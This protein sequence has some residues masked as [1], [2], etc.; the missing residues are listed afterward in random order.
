MAWPSYLL[1]PL[2][3]HHVAKGPP[4]HQFVV[5]APVCPKYVGQPVLIKEVHANKG[6]VR[7]QFRQ[8]YPA[9]IN[10]DMMDCTVRLA[11][12]EVS[13]RL[14]CIGNATPK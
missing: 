10:I 14:G 5:I 1:H 8:F 4:S 7:N 12:N 2:S 3:G 11:N 13:R 6:W 9:T